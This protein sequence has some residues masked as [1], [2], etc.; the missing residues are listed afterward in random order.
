MV[1]LL[2]WTNTR[3]QGFIQRREKG[4]G[5]RVGG[6]EGGRERGVICFGAAIQ[7]IRSPLVK[8]FLRASLDKTTEYPQNT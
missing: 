6:R 2:A 7:V 5:E 1:K 8:I 4:N 3:R